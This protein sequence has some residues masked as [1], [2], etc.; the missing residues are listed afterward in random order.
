MKNTDALSTAA[1][2]WTAHQLRVLAATAM[3]DPRT[4]RRW[5]EGRAI[6]STCAARLE[7]AATE[8]G[9]DRAMAV[10]P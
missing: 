1:P 3:V 2:R 7:A 8:I 5:I 4:A 6:S 10:R 9:R